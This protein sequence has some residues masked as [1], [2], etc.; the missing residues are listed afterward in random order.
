M[1]SSITRFYGIA[2]HGSFSPIVE[3]STTAGSG[4]TYTVSLGTWTERDEVVNLSFRVVYSGLGE[5]A[6]GTLY[7]RCPNAP[8]PGFE[9]PISFYLSGVATGAGAGDQI[10][11]VITN[12]DNTTII[13]FDIL[14]VGGGGATSG[15]NIVN[16]AAAT[17]AGSCTFHV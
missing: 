17:I 8:L 9:T 11:A 16:A 7:I 3:G 13:R 2:S 1:T 10:C 14:D 12:V 15:V 6:A 5:G 4:A